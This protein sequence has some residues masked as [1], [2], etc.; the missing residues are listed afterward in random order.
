MWLMIQF[1]KKGL[2]K[3]NKD[4]AKVEAGDCELGFK[5]CHKIEYQ[6]K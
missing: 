4:K 3:S 2:E 5:L 1:Q 6:G